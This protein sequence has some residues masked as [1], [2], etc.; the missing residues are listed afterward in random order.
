MNTGRA[1]TK[2]GLSTRGNAVTFLRKH[3]VVEIPTSKRVLGASHKLNLNHLP[4]DKPLLKIDDQIYTVSDIKYPTTILLYKGKGLVC[5]TAYDEPH[6]KIVYDI[7]P[8][9]FQN[10]HPILACVGRLDKDTTGLLIL[11]QDGTLQ[12]LIN[13]SHVPKTYHA[14]I[15]PDIPDEQVFQQQI[16]IPFA[17]GIQLHGENRPCRPA[18]AT[19]LDKNIVSVTL[20]EGMY[21]QVKRMFSS[22]EYTVE[23]LH[24]VSVGPFHLSNEQL[25]EN[26]WRSIQQAEIEQY[27]KYKSNA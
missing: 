2:L 19:L 23:E 16:Q 26:E 3:T 4:D 24:R 21:H 13:S 20:F 18:K 12:D 1:L 22:R 17:T 15:S 8:E 5:S 9:H 14:T 6:S 27:F 10:M 25:K 7:L 11:T